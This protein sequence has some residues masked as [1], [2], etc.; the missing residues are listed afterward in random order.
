[1][2]DKY[3]CV[4]VYYATDEY[5]S[6]LIMDTTSGL[7][8]GDISADATPSANGWKFTDTEEVIIIDIVPK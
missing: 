6:W 1:V 2:K 3:G 4:P 7:Y 8:A 5:G